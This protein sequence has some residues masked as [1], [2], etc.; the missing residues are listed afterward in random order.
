MDRPQLLLVVIAFMAA[1]LAL[2]V[3]GWRERKRRQK[4]ITAP[5]SAPAD[6]GDVLG[7]FGGKYVATTTSGDPL[8]RIAVHGLG[9]RGTV[10]VDVAAIGLLV[11][12]AGTKPIWIPAADLLARR[13]ATWTIDRVV[14]H[15]GLEL[16]EW[17]LGDRTVDSYFRFDDARDFELAIDTLIAGKAS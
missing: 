2:M 5:V 8:D 10:T 1:L 12:I 6:L 17:K 9:F 7:S 11:R 4:S 15:D 13:K 14:E 16:L 3:L